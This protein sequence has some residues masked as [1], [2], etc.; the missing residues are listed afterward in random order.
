MVDKEY[1]NLKLT[2]REL[3]TI[4]VTL[5]DKA[6]TAK[7]NNDKTTEYVLKSILKTIQIELRFQ[8]ED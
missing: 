5:F 8:K 4:Q 2:K 7:Q 6:M 1:I 3:Q